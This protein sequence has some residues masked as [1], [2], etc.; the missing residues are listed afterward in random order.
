[1]ADITSSADKTMNKALSVVIVLAIIG[2][3]I[4]LMFTNLG[5][6]IANFTNV[7]TGNE[8]V[9]LIINSALVLVVGLSVPLGIVKLVQKSTNVGK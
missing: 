2:A 3:T 7:D 5:N 8:T 4:G 9:D 1:M 6:I